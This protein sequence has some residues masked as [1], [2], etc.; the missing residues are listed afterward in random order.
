MT[1][2][3]RLV[4]LVALSIRLGGVAWVKWSDRRFVRGYEA[5]KNRSPSRRRPE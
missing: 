4:P 5:E 2:F 3:D 1:T